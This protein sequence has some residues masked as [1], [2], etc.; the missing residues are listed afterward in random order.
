VR[1]AC[2]P[3]LRQIAVAEG[4]TAAFTGRPGGVS[5]AP[6]GSLNL[7][8]SIGD[9]A[10]AV[11]RNRDVVR[12]AL[13]PS[14]R[15]LVFLRQVHGTTVCRAQAGGDDPAEEADAVFTDAPGIALGILVA[16]CAP[17]LVADPQAQVVGAAHAGRRGLAD[18]VVPALVAAMA[19]IG[20]EPSRMLA[21][22]G[23]AICGG[24]Y[25]VPA[26][27][28]AEVDRSA[29]GSAC[30]TR[31]GTPGIDLRAGLRSQLARAG[32]GEIGHD[33]RCTAE[34]AE[35][36]SYRRDGRTGRFAGLIW[37]TGS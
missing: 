31:S 2:L 11:G 22:V 36:F 27:M 9:D 13:G 29:P 37:L 6:F 34:T 16:D 15:R 35:L 30:I 4:V 20:G 28:R 24:C 19:A 18:G 17:V 7:G 25:E 5:S 8:A 14:A 12:T 26:E 10:A 33:S 1:E 32:V 3:G 21:I 23:P